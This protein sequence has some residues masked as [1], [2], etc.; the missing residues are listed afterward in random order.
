MNKPVDIEN[1]VRQDWSAL[2]AFDVVYYVEKY[3]FQKPNFK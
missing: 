3:K 2:T 1:L